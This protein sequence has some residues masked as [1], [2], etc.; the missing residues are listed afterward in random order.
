MTTY[1][2]ITFNKK[3]CNTL[4]GMEDSSSGMEDSSSALESSN[5][6]SITSN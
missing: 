4:S 3:F 1:E 6:P 2:A 5:K